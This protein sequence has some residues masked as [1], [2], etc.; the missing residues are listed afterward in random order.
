MSCDQI[1]TSR[2]MSTG[3]R[4][5]RYR[6]AQNISSRLRLAQDRLVSYLHVWPI[7]CPV[8]WSLFWLASQLV[9]QAVK[10]TY[11]VIRNINSIVLVVV[12]EAPQSNQFWAAAGGSP[13]PTNVQLIVCPLNWG[14]I[15]F[16]IIPC[17]IQSVATV[18]NDDEGICS[19]I[20]TFVFFRVQR[21]RERICERISKWIAHL[22]DDDGQW[23]TYMYIHPSRSWWSELWHQFVIRNAITS[24]AEIEENSS[25]W[26]RWA[27]I[28]SW[29]QSK[30]KTMK[31]RFRLQDFNRSDLLDWMVGDALIFPWICQMVCWNS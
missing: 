15:F 18:T 31:R 24:S 27:T 11:A 9:H 10:L 1:G 19:N 28:H 6:A 16:H 3:A 14:I 13:A 7:S 2:S 25:K 5:R 30:Q 29:W 21:R 26:T 4:D 8:R 22:D 23:F 20:S 12:F 17:S